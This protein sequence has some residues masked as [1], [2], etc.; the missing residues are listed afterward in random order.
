MVIVNSYVKL[1]EGK[2]IIAVLSKPQ[3]GPCISPASGFD[4]TKGKGAVPPE[5]HA[6]IRE[7]QV[8]LMD[9]NPSTVMAIY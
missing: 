4:S 8:K 1:P 7:S 2:S 9:V 5:G 6:W 3:R